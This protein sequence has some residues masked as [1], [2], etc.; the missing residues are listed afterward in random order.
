MGSEMCIRD[1]GYFARVDAE[2][3]TAA[4]IEIERSIVAGRLQADSLYVFESDPLWN[5][6]SAQRRPA[7]VVGVLDGFRIIAPGLA[8]CAACNVADVKLEEAPG[9][10]LGS[11][12]VFGAEVSR[13]YPM[14]GWGLPE[15][16]GVWSQDR[17]TSLVIRL[18][19]EP[20]RDLVLT[21]E[22]L[23]LIHI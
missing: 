12:I 8:G 6:A 2:K 1:S 11:R 23:S 10:V 7:D 4:R 5:L 9:Y 20:A 15:P 16:W 18:A 19:R 3:L 14:A 22:A 21:L 17:A 13:R